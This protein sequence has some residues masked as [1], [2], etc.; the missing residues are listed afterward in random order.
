MSWE[1]TTH[2]VEGNCVAARA[3]WRATGDERTARRLTNPIR[4]H[5]SASLL[6]H[7]EARN[8]PNALRWLVKRRSGA[9]CGWGRDVRKAKRR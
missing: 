5:V 4:R 3:G 6:I 8:L 2:V 1:V 9:W 7:G